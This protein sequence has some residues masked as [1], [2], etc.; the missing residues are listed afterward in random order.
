MR[1]EKLSSSH[2]SIHVLKGA[3]FSLNPL[4]VVQ[5][6]IV[7]SRQTKKLD[8]LSIPLVAYN[9]RLRSHWLTYSFIVTASFSL[10]VIVGLLS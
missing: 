8:L 3:D 6:E 7:P 4:R 1:D 10:T 9:L 2:V 5:G